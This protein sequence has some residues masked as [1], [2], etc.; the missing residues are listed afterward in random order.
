MAALKLIRDG[1]FALADRE[2]WYSKDRTQVVLPQDPQRSDSIFCVP[3]TKI[4]IAEARK[5]GLV[6]KPP[7]KESAPQA[8][9][10]SRPE[11]TKARK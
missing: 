6:G 7:L 10:E 3:G 4:P 8:T 9:K 11:A 2:L 5:F 1:K